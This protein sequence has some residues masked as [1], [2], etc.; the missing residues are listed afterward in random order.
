[1]IQRLML[2]SVSTGEASVKKFIEIMKR[3]IEDM[4]ED[5]AVRRMIQALVREEIAERKG[6]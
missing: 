4:R 1:M 5:R 2:T 6:V 3:A